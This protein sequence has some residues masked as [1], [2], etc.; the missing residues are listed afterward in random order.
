MMEPMIH[1][2]YGS[3]VRG[4]LGTCPS[5]DCR[6]LTH[7]LMNSGHSGTTGIG[8]VFSGNKPQSEGWCQ[9]SSCRLL[10]RCWRTPC[11]NFLTSAISSSRVISLRSSSIE[12]TIFEGFENAI[13]VPSHLASYLKSV[14]ESHQKQA[15]TR[16]EANR[17]AKVMRGRA[18][19]SAWAGMSARLIEV[20]QCQACAFWIGESYASCRV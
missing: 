14:A 5:S 7:P 11:R 20:G 8:S 17:T 13:I 18:E 12:F 6:Y 19:V 3:F 9:Q 1:F 4:A 2:S 10:S 16:I 15:H